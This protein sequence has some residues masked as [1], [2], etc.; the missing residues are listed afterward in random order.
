MSDQKMSA[1]S[2]HALY[3]RMRGRSAWGRPKAQIA[4]TDRQIQTD[5]A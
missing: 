4:D 3:E 2:F 1:A 5:L